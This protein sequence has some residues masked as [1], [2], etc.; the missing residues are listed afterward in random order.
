[1]NGVVATLGDQDMET[2]AAY[3]ASLD[4]PCNRNFIA[5]ESM[6]ERAVDCSPST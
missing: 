2:F 4:Y 1:M 5:A 3:C 6:H